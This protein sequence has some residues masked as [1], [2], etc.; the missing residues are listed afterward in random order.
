MTNCKTSSSPLSHTY[1]NPIRLE[2]HWP[3]SLPL[4]NTSKGISEQKYREMVREREEKKVCVRVQHQDK[5]KEMEKGLV[6]AAES[7]K[8]EAWGAQGAACRSEEGDLQ[9]FGRHDLK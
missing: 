5:D 2:Q 8:G 1:K 7:R 3:S 4:L 9:F 6:G